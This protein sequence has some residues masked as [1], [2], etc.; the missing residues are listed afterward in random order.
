MKLFHPILKGIFLERPNRFTM[1]CLSENRRIRAFLP[2]PGRMWELLL[3]GTTVFLE[4]ASNPENKMPYVCVAV[5]REGHP[6]ILHT[7]RTNDLTQALLEKDLIPG[8]EGATI[9]KREARYRHSRFDFLLSRG[10]EEIFLEVKSCTLFGKETAMFPDAITAR[11][12]RHLEEL[13]E[14]PREGKKGAVLFLIGWP[15]AKYFL[16]DFHTDL[17]FSRTFL[18]VRGKVEI[19]PAAVE[20]G[21]DLSLRADVRLL[22]VPWDI[23][24]QET[25][26]RGSYIIVLRLDRKANVEIGKLGKVNFP[27]GYYLYVG[28]AMKNLA[29]RVERHRRVLKNKFW[30][31]DYLR[32]QTTFCAAIPIRS[33][34][35]LECEISRSLKNLADWQIA[36]F[37]CSDCSCSSHLYGLTGDPFLSRSFISL[38]QDFRMDR[39]P[40]AFRQ[41]RSPM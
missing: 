30:H 16:P 4:K 36:G 40:G 29:S 9:I 25:E 5:E 6:V 21:P 12:K 10:R 31:I 41:K 23:I 27:K 34:V 13:A 24:R 15:H 20:F 35:D 18:K 28:S 39:L 14:L 8:L 1:I 26:D 33:S 11:G 3:P 7:M 2:N 38:L 32:E 17:E 22:K 19:Y 37:G